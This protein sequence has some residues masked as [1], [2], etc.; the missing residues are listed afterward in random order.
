[1]RL[2][3]GDPQRNYLFSSLQPDSDPRSAN[4]L[5]GLPVIGFAVTEFTGGVQEGLL[6]NFSTLTEHAGERAPVRGVL[7]ANFPLG[8]WTPETRQ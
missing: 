4:L 7:D 3:L 2:E 5:L 1:M 6:A 8:G